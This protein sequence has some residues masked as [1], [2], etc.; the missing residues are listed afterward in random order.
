M[1]LPN[2]FPS[3]GIG[4]PIGGIPT[5]QTGAA[6]S[7]NFEAPD[8]NKNSG[9]SIYDAGSAAD[10]YREYWENGNVFADWFGNTD[11]FSH[12]E[13]IAAYEREKEASAEAFQRESDYNAKEA[14]KQRQYEQYLSDTAFQRKVADYV[15]A[16]FSPLAALE[17]SVGASTPSGSAASAN[18]QA[19]KAPVAQHGSN[20]LGSVLGAIVA[21]L[22]M[23]ATK[24]LSGKLG[25]SAKAV[26]GASEAKAV[27]NLAKDA[28][29]QSGKKGGMMLGGKWY[30]DDQLVKI[31]R[32]RWVAKD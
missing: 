15:K 19:A 13:A 27:S 26:S 16:G 29:K 12:N 11:T 23:V 10:H 18:Y 24:G 7:S 9:R 22:A 32:T 30:T 5:A 4:I 6:T 2:F 3:T 14:E 17:G 1:G 21:A 31:A 25:A 28:L 8:I 20:N